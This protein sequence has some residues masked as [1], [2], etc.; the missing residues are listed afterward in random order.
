MMT[1]QWFLSTNTMFA[2]LPRNTA[3]QAYRAYLGLDIAKSEGLVPVAGEP[4]DVDNKGV[5]A[6]ACAVCHSTLDPL[7][8]AFSAYNGLLGGAG[9][10]VREVGAYNPQRTPWENDGY[11]WGQPVADLMEWRQLAIESDE[12]KQNITQMFYEYAVGRL[13]QTDQ[14]KKDFRELWQGFATADQYQAERLIHRLIET[15][16]FA[17]VTP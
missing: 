16:S 6:P 9:G 1:T 4:R 13:P 3:A 8:Y 7:A 15:L 5:T 11:L 14:E 12:F 2:I 10:E 17:G